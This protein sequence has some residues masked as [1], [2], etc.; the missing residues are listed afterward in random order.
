MEVC[1]FLTIAGVGYALN[2]YR[3]PSG[4]TRPALNPAA[5]P[6]LQGDAPSSASLYESRRLDA[7]RDDEARRAYA[8]MGAGA[9]AS[10]PPPPPIIHST[11]SGQAIPVERFTHNN[12]VPF[13]GG[14]V[15]Q[16]VRDDAFQGRLETFTGSAAD[17]EAGAARKLE[18]EPLFEP[19]R[20]DLHGLTSDATRGAFMGVLHEPRNRAFEQPA[21]VLPQRAGVASPETGDVYY[22]IRAAA[23][24]RTLD[25]LRSA[26]NPRLT[27]EGRVLPGQGQTNQ[28][29]AIARVEVS[30][31][32]TVV[33]RGVDDFLRTT[34]AMLKAADR[35]AELVKDTV[36]QATTRDYVGTAG[37]VAAGHSTA[38][39]AQGRTPFRTSL[40][41]PELGPATGMVDGGKDDHGMSSIQV[42]ANE[43][44]VTSTR[45]YQ[46]SLAS[47]FKAAVAPLQDLVRGTRKEEFSDAPRAFGNVGPGGVAQ[48]KLTIYDAED[49]ARTTLKQTSVVSA[50]P[51]NL[52]GGAHKLTVYD[53]E[54]VARVNRKQT[55][56]ASAPNANMRGPAYK[57]TIYDP[58]DVARTTNKQT[59]LFDASAGSSFVPATRRGR[60][61]DPEDRTRT[62]GRQ[63]VAPG[64]T[65]RNVG[66]GRAAGASYDPESWAPAPTSKQILTDKGR[67]DYADG[68]V[69]AVV[70]QRGGAYATNE[71]EARLTQKA[72]LADSGTAF[73]GAYQ[74]GGA[75]Y[76][77]APD[78]VRDTQRQALADTEYFG[79]MGSAQA[80]ASMASYKAAEAARTNALRELVSEGRDPTSSSVKLAAG[81]AAAG[82]A[83]REPQRATTR[84]PLE[85]LGMRPAP[86]VQIGAGVDALPA[87]ALNGRNAYA[88]GGVDSRLRD[89][90]AGASLQL[91]GNP[92]A[93]TPF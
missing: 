43:R 61:V 39:D 24:P 74:D 13:Y 16:N 35:P 73:G 28:R 10:A 33:E 70:G 86:T 85:E 69:G 14:S 52:V 51:A 87:V 8:M 84:V 38:Q 2:K 21:P 45:T 41:G 93:M 78:D 46:G 20:E 59:Q 79:S 17:G 26:S 68:N 89:E 25:D 63:T 56:L 88:D 15:R 42:Y 55:T 81:A 9:G 80:G 23:M 76:E 34:G 77:V 71:Y 36:R 60:A 91:S 6:L 30:H 44:D 12:M 7:V 11:L 1:L 66:R 5:A 65:V 75:G 83:N 64:D 92:V 40:R 62:T 27:F 47:A 67:G 72:Q 3:S 57:L 22:D 31:P 19:R 90:I 54:D 53:P 29:P 37:G 82:E 32:S 49:V 48:P 50:A 4:A 18:R 58:E